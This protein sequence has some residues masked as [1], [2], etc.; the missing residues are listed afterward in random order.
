MFTVRYGLYLYVHLTE[1]Q[2]LTSK[3]P[4]AQ[5][6]ITLL[7]TNTNGQ[8]PIVTTLIP[9]KRTATGPT[10]LGAGWASDGQTD[11][12]RVGGESS[13]LPPELPA[14]SLL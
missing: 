6:P 13:L 12:L 8:H 9:V 4:S 3:M 14:S 2:C 5:Q 10:A 1:T 7:H 11:G